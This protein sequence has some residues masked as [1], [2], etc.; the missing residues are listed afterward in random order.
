MTTLPQKRTDGVLEVKAGEETLLYD[1]ARNKAHC[2]NRSA[3]LVWERCDGKSTVQDTVA[4][5]QR[6]LDASANEEVVHYA[7]HQ[8]EKARLLSGPLPPAAPEGLTRRKFLRRAALLTL[9]AILAPTV[10]SLLVPTPAAAQTVTCVA[11][12]T[13]Q[14]NC[15]Q[16]PTPQCNKV[17]WNQSCVAKALAGC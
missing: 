14:P 11:S 5:L 15:L 7:L 13:G 6:E 1:R 12:C 2:L 3:A 10:S 16:C 8:F 17:C 9:G 4:A